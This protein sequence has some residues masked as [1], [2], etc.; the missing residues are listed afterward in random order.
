MMKFLVF[1]WIKLKNFIDYKKLNLLEIEIIGI[2]DLNVN[3]IPIKEKVKV[4]SKREITKTEIVPQPKVE[5]KVL[6][7][8]V[9]PNNKIHLK[10]KVEFLD[11]K[12]IK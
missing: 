9:V 3:N 1:L 2:F 4:L 6:D 11:E 5:V 7:A 12:N 8:E 10:E